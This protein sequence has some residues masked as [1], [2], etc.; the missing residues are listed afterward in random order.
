MLLENIRFKNRHALKLEIKSPNNIT[1][2]LKSFGFNENRPVIVI[3]GGAG[4]IKE[5][6]WAAIKDAIRVIAN[7][8]QNAGAAVI[9]GGTDSGVMAAIGEAR[10]QKGYTFPLIG[11]AAEGTVTWPGRKRNLR[12]GLFGKKNYGPLDPNHT[13]FILVPGNNWGD[14]SDWISKTATQLAG[15]KP[16]I[17]ILIN[18]GMISRNQDVPNNL[19]TGRV[20]LVIE[21]TGRAADDFATHPPK[22][23]LMHFIHISE[24]DRLATELQEHL[25]PSQ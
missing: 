4:G 23:E 1:Q 25:Q 14:E 12:Q 13:H 16:S 24:Q 17:A 22:T 18:G 5:E 15:E 10:I 9:D 7:A 8:A 6:D 19:K 3:I 2:A 11:V 21:G 20:V